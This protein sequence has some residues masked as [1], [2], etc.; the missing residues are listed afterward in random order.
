LLGVSSRGKIWRIDP[1]ARIVM[2]HLGLNC[3]IGEQKNRCDVW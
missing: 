3:N 2:Q 1:P